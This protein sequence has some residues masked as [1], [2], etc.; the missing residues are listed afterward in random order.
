MNEAIRT[1]ERYLKHRADRQKKNRKLS[2]VAQGILDNSIKNIDAHE[3][4]KEEIKLLHESRENTDILRLL[5]ILG[6]L[7]ELDSMETRQMILDQAD[8]EIQLLLGPPDGFNL[9]NPNDPVAIRRAKGALLLIR[10]TPEAI[11]GL[12]Y[13]TERLSP[14]S[15]PWLHLD[16]KRLMFSLQ[17][18]LFAIKDS[19]DPGNEPGARVT[20][21]FSDFHKAFSQFPNIVYAASVSH[22][23]KIRFYSDDALEKATLGFE[24]YSMYSD[25]LGKSKYEIFMRFKETI[26]AHA[27]VKKEIKR[28]FESPE[29]KGILDALSKAPSGFSAFGNV[30]HLGDRMRDTLSLMKNPWGH[31]DRDEM[32]G[33]Y[34]KYM[35]QWY[36]YKATQTSV[37]R[38]ISIYKGEQARWEKLRN[39]WSERP[40]LF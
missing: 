17:H 40:L 21:A 30:R 1:K 18:I 15:N 32:M 5:R 11:V 13:I 36:E 27:R 29:T 12:E 4:V 31:V 14:K 37:R 39:G 35:A 25:R 22:H 6:K 10:L 23:G 9:N 16:E 3:R 33:I 7:A 8:D 24:K 2:R 19:F 34:M 28:L 26:D 38:D 20:E